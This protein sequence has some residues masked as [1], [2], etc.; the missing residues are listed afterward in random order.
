MKVCLPK[1]KAARAIKNV[2]NIDE[3]RKN[4]KHQTRS[5]QGLN[6]CFISCFPPS[7][8]RLAEYSYHLINELQRLPEIG[9]IEIIADAEEY[10]TKTVNDKITLH[11]VW[12]VDK[13]TS[14]LFVPLKILRLKPD[15]VHFNVHMAVFGRSRLANF[16]GLSLPLVCRLMGFRTLVTL[17]NITEMI[18]IEKT[19]FRN[20][21]LNRLGAFIATKLL[22]IAS[23]VTL[24]VR[25]YVKILRR[26]YKCKRALWIPHGTWNIDPTNCGQSSHN[27]KTILYIG[28][29]GP[30]K[31]LELLFQAFEILHEKRN[32]VKLMVAGDS[33]PNYPNFLDK[34][35]RGN[36]SPNVQ[37]TG[38]VPEERFQTL[39]EKVDVVVLPYRTCTGTSGVVAHLAASYGVPIVATDLPEF[40]ELV[41]EGCG[42]VLSPHNP[43]TLAEKIEYILNNP[44]LAHELRERNLRFAQRRTW[45]KVAL[46][47][48][49]VYKEIGEK[50]RVRNVG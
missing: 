30:Y 33:H 45:N 3:G 8:G 16:V 4:W 35:K 29:S 7:R 2:A 43:V 38:F 46:S 44:D 24:T 20:T 18:D 21:F 14:L 10:C 17:H 27:T 47:F 13:P 40:R 19:G 28:H 9:H 22:I 25:S 37:F 49:E 1:H 39:F 11:R 26:R 6:I 42:I 50:M 5:I 41:D 23:A 12:K 34:Y 15:V 31:D 36:H 32:A 48:C